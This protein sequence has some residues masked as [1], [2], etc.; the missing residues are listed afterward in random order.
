MNE[1]TKFYLRQDQASTNQSLCVS[2][3]KLAKSIIKQLA[4]THPTALKI[5]WID[6][7]KGALVSYGWCIDRSI[8]LDDDNNKCTYLTSEGEI[9][10]SGLKY[11]KLDDSEI[12]SMSYTRQNELFTSL[13]DFLNNLTN[14]QKQK[15][16]KF[17]KTLRN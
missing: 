1:L 13:S 4:N 8:I 11:A 15:S 7:N 2:I 14:R 12:N 5:N 10:M 16:R 9:L 3:R 17:F 6:P